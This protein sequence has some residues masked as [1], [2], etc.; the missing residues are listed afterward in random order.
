[1]SLN[2]DP[3]HD[4]TG[5]G[6]WSHSELAEQLV[7]RGYEIRMD[8]EDNEHS[9]VWFEDSKVGDIRGDNPATVTSDCDSVPE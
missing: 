6:E 3:A 5:N 2:P 1:M 4:V 8:H 9:E 7:M